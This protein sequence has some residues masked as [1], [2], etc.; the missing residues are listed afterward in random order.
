MQFT[1]HYKLYKSLRSER[2]FDIAGKES[3]NFATLTYFS[4]SWTLNTNRKNRRNR[5]HKVAIRVN[6]NIK[7][8]I[9]RLLNMTAE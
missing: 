6:V 8:V 5:V 1:H 9:D 2:E 3:T 7:P 4:E